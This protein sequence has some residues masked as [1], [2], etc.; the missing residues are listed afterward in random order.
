MASHVLCDCEALAALR[1]Q[2]L[3]RHF[4]KPGDLEEISVSRILHFVQGV[5]LLNA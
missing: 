4:V 3:C 1:S 5:E 2:L